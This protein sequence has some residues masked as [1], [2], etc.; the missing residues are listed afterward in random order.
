MHLVETHRILQW[1]SSVQAVAILQYQEVQ[2]L[3]PT[4]REIEAARQRLHESRTGGYDWQ[5]VYA[6]SAR[7]FAADRLKSF[8]V[9]GRYIK[10]GAFEASLILA[11]PESYT[12][13]QRFAS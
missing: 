2:Q 8:I 12:D 11:Y 1:N 6:S 3:E 10:R 5:S 4:S 13:S 9:L 7:H